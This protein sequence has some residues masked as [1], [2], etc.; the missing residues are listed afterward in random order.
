MKTQIS[1]ILRFDIPDATNNFRE[2]VFDLYAK[3]KLSTEILN[4]V[5]KSLVDISLGLTKDADARLVS[6]Y[7]HWETLGF[8]TTEISFIFHKS[9]LDVGYNRMEMIILSS[10]K[11]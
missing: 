10:E 5:F 3:Y 8:T 11:S 6:E 1:D 2:Y 4:Y 7:T 9:I